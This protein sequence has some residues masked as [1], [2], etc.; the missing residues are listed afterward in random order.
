PDLPQPPMKTPAPM[1][2]GFEAVRTAGRWLLALFRSI[3]EIVWAYLFVRLFGL[4]VLPAIL[5]IGLAVGGSIGKLYSELAEAVEPRAV[6]ALRAMGAS[7]TSILL[8][9]VLPQVGRQWIAY[10]LFR[11]ECNIRTGTILGVVGA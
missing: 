9:S 4:G 7:R 8:F 11:L 2:Y 6:R 10:A 3:P 1:R 5:A